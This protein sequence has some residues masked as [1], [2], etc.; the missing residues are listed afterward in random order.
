[1]RI[2]VILVMSLIAFGSSA[3]S[4]EPPFSPMFGEVTPPRPPGM[5]G[6]STSHQSHLPATRS[7]RAAATV[8]Q[9]EQ[10]PAAAP[11]LAKPNVV[12]IGQSAATPRPEVTGSTSQ[13][14]AFPAAQTLE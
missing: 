6:R 13:T 8:K 10:K 12:T 5:I 14:P 1:V 11:A 3:A 2:R 7:G 9:P 4:A